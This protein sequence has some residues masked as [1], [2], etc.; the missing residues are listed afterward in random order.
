VERRGSNNFRAI[1]V[2]AAIAVGTSLATIA[3]G[4]LAGPENDSFSAR[5]NLGD[6]L[7]ADVAESNDDATQQSG[8]WFGKDATGHSIWWQWT[9]P[10]TEMVTV[11]SCES[12]F[13][14][15][16]GVFEGTELGHLHRIGV[17]PTRLGPGCRSPYAEY[18]F[19][20]EAGMTYVIGVDG[21]GFYEPGRRGGPLVEPPSGEGRVILRVEPSSLPG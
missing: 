6:T 14:T 19:Y 16:L 15:L 9:S 17:A 11:S 13:P 21:N 8:E 18:D 2:C 5:A 7:P 1:G 10:A 12:S 20:A 3:P 4:A